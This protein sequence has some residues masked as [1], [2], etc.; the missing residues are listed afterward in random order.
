MSDPFSTHCTSAAE[1]LVVRV[2]GRV[3]FGRDL[4]ATKSLTEGDA[5]GQAMAATSAALVEAEHT[6]SDPLRPFKIWQ[7][8]S[9]PCQVKRELSCVFQAAHVE[10][11]SNCL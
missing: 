6:L 5:P 2:A 1:R 10:N 8:V 11:V 4:G 9:V 7:K 3:G